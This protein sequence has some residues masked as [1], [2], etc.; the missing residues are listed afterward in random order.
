MTLPRAFWCHVDY[1]G[2][3]VENAVVSGITTPLPGRALAWMRQA[4]REVVPALDRDSFCAAWAWLGDHHGE[5]I[6]VRELRSG[7][8]YAFEVSTPEGCWRWRA[9]LVSVLPLA[10][11]CEGF[12]TGGVQ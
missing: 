5:G 6:A 7:R 4:V 2:C 3:S 12:Y 9:H 1:A 11:A 8:P 10:D